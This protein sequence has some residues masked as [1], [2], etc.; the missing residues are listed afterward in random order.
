[1][2]RLLQVAG[3]QSF[4]HT[5]AQLR[6]EREIAKLEAEAAASYTEQGYA[7]LE[8]RPHW[9]DMS[10]LSIRYL[11]T[12]E[13]DAATSE[14]VTDPAQWSAYLTEDWAYV[15]AETGEPV[16][17]DLVDDDTREDPNL[18]PEEVVVVVVSPNNKR[19]PNRVSCG[20][21]LTCCDA[22]C[23][24][25]C[26]LASVS[27]SCHFCRL[28]HSAATDASAYPWC[29]RVDGHLLRHCDIWAK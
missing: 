16:D 6:T 3:S 22:R 4:D 1:V 10:C 7:V 25:R 26:H 2:R 17:P 24:T 13:G 12:P 5:V 20:D 29:C 21:R 19:S 9:D 23:L 28:R 11:R 8:Q 18:E 27:N 15:D 14:V